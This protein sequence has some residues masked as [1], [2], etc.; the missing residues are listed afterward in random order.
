[1]TRRDGAHRPCLATSLE[2]DGTRTRPHERSPV[3]RRL[4]SG[5]PRLTPLIFSLWLGGCF[6]FDRGPTP[7]AEARSEAGGASTGEPPTGLCGNGRLDEGEECD[8]GNALACD[9]CEGCMRRRYLSFDGTSA[10]LSFADSQG[11]PLQLAGSARTVE[12]WVRMGGDPSYRIDLYRRDAKAGWRLGAQ[13]NMVYATVFAQWDHLVP[14]TM[15]TKWHHLAWTWDGAVSRLWVDGK[16]ASSAAH[17]GTVWKATTPLRIVAEDIGTP[18]GD[19]DEVR[20]S[21]VIRYDK[22][23]VPQR[24]FT[25]D[26]AT[27]GL[28]HFDEKTAPFADAS[29]RSHTGMAQG[30]V[31]TSSDDCYA[32]TFSQ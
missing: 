18:R 22:P 6:E 12:V 7:E 21:T 32:G 3:G 28:W 5:V 27:V 20:V 1:M 25:T 17:E 23:F 11:T 30:I 29:G 4:C 14:Y 10:E 13:G 26:E 15:D 31:P 2:V 19:L 16:L 9:G 24:R 8:D